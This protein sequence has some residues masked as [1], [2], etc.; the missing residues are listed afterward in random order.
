VAYL[1]DTNVLSEPLRPSPDALVLEHLREHRSDL[2]TAS[3]VWHELVFGAARL[4]PSR[5]RRAIERYLQDVVWATMPVLAYDAAAAEWHAHE[6]ARLAEIGNPR[7]FVDGQIAA[8]ARVN[9]LI[10]V[11][12]NVA[13]FVAFSG[14]IVE[15][16][17]A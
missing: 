13:D 1:L 16:W 11:T 2:V 9:E 6:R 15:D 17:R 10:L 7:P 12:A 14:L 4:P 8:I 3:P 5:R